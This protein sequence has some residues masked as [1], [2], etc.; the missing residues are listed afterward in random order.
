MSPRTPRI[1]A[2]AAPSLTLS[3]IEEF[4][5]R[6]SELA[7]EEGAALQKLASQSMPGDE[8]AWRTEF[9][10]A[11]AQLDRQTLQQRVDELQEKQRGEGLDD[12]DKAEL[13]ELLQRR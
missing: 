6:K 12:A 9:L 11:I 4:R 13:R 8:V 10:D 3:S 7:G 2:G 5:L 1:L